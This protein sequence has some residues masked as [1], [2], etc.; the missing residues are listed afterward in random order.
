MS[1][2]TPAREG[3][4]KTAWIWS[5]GLLVHLACAVE[6]RSPDAESTNETVETSSSA[7][8]V[9]RAD[10]DASSRVASVANARASR[11]G[12]SAAVYLSLSNPLDHDL[13][14]REVRVVEGAQGA[15][16]HETRMQGEVMRM[17]PVDGLAVPA[18]ETVDLEPGGLH[19]MLS[20]V[21]TEA[22][23]LELVLVFDQ[24]PPLPFEV[25]L[26]APR[27]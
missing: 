13:T 12:D 5:A 2:Q 7:E 27:P 1:K 18:G 8:I 22:R 4:L 20:G 21:S 19:V 3:K 11:S 9:T 10:S 15:T 26:P 14:L 16:V 24:G 6:P 17:R 23:T 25:D